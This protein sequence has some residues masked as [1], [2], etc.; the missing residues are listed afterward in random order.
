MSLQRNTDIAS[1]TAAVS[2]WIHGPWQTGTA[3][4]PPDVYV[5]NGDN[6]SISHF[7][8]VFITTFLTLFNG[9]YGFSSFRPSSQ[10]KPRKSWAADPW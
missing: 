1:M 5:R 4:T 9:Y 2:V 7:C 10:L 8:C 3:N 6:A